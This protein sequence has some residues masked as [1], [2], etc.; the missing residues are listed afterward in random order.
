MADM[1]WVLRSLLF[2][3]GH[4][5]DMIRKA[6]A[7][8]T[9][10]I[11]L[12]L[13][14]GVAPAEKPAARR[15]IAAALDSTLPDGLIVLLRTNSTASGLLDAD[16]REAARPRLNGI[17]LPKCEAPSEVEAAAARLLT[18]EDRL[19]LPRGRLRLLALVETARGVLAAPAIARQ[20]DRVFGLVF[21]AEDFTADAEMPRTRSGAELAAARTAVSLAAHAAGV[22]AIDG[23]F[24]DF[25]DEPGL[26]ADTDEAR[27]L[28]YTAKTLIHPAQIGPVH[29]VF[30]PGPD[31]VAK[32]R[33]IVDEFTRGE[34]AGS[35]IVVVDG[36]MV[37]RPVAVRA[38]RLLARAAR[39]G[40]GV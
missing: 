25:R 7:S 17:C 29:R 34:A 23:I 40:A 6:A 10:G 37:D 39:F 13:E 1:A 38:Q 5:G 26:V 19:G 28:G 21:G 36:A 18:V 4:R 22:E 35:G 31:E 33:R 32:A 11:I 9:D 14:D 20:S 3:P 27:R 30:A 16:L 12:D 8:G 24:A 15:T 2:V